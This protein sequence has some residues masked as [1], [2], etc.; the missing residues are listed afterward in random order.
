MLGLPLLVAVMD[1]SRSY[2]AGILNGRPQPYT[3]HLQHSLMYWGV[4][5]LILPLPL[6]MIWKHPLGKGAFSRAL[7]VH[8]VAAIGFA[9][10]HSCGL[11]L[12][13]IVTDYSEWG[14]LPMVVVKLSSSMIANI[15]LYVAIV[16]TVHALRFHDEAQ[17]RE[18]TAAQLQASLTQ[19]RLTAL[20]SQLNPHFL[21]NTLNAISALAIKGDREEVSQTLGTLGDLLRISLDDELPQEIPLAQELEFLD[22]YL[23]IQRTRFGTRLRVIQHLDPGTP[24]AMVPSMI[25]QPLV[26]NAIEHGLAA[27]PGPGEVHVT[28]R[29]VEG[30]LVID[31]RDT[32]PGLRAGELRRP[33]GI[34]LT[35]TRARL[36][37]LHGDAA[38][39]VLH[40]ASDGG[41]N[42]RLSVP[43]RTAGSA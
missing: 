34:G 3:F 23:D 20:R 18:V 8:L 21:F 19:A 17:A 43:W 22:R 37:Q 33:G 40:E 32:G 7:G 31:V 28:A 1:A 35:N 13:W 39:L 9:L 30:D 42:A 29:R 15:I 24:D 41:T 10:L 14:A 26:E 12:L 4:V 11:T 6:Y 2:V 27:I 25:L 5:A 16:G 38:S 36:H